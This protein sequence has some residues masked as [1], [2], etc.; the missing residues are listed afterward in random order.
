MTVSKHLRFHLILNTATR[1]RTW[2]S[3]CFHPQPAPLPSDAGTVIVALSFFTPDSY[4]PLVR[5]AN[6][7]TVSLEHMLC[8]AKSLI[9]LGM[10]HIGAQIFNGSWTRK[11]TAG[12]N[13]VWRF[14]ILLFGGSFG[15]KTAKES[16]P[17]LLT[18]GEVLET[19]SGWCRSFLLLHRS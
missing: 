17:I 7:S 5:S 15:V 16:L 2:H 11:A 18:V 1:K 6:R 19:N 8:P 4:F 10:D 3:Q 13:L 14:T 12:A 9:D